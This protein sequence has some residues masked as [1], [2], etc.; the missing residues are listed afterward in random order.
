MKQ[1]KTSY[2]AKSFSLSVLLETES[3]EV[4]TTSEDLGLC[5]N[6]HTSNTVNF[7]LH[8]RV[9]VRVAEVGEMRAP[10][11]VLCVAFDNDGILIKSIRESK[12]SLRLLPAVQIV[13]L[14]AS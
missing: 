2:L 6:A 8:V 1:C 14:F 12:C 5:Q 3:R 4:H 7:H 11:G 13:R 10:S 9:T